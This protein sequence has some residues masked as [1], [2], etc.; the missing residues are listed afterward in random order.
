MSPMQA[1]ICFDAPTE[2]D[3]GW[4]ACWRPPRHSGPLSCRV[5]LHYRTGAEGKGLIRKT[6]PPTTGDDKSSG[7][8]ARADAAGGEVV[9][10]SSGFSGAAYPLPRRLASSAM[11]GMDS[12]LSSSVSDPALTASSRSPGPMAALSTTTETPGLLRRSSPIRALPSPSGRARST[13]ATSRR[14]SRSPSSAFAGFGERACLGHHLEIGLACEQEGQSF[15]EGGLV[16]HEHDP[17]C[18]AYTHSVSFPGQR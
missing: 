14:P 10:A 12:T 5:I 18:L 2:G 3:V 1:D 15:A 6:A 16:L 4:G 17:D 7:D 9:S 13:T 11:V 8:P